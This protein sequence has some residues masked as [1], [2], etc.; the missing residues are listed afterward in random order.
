MQPFLHLTI[1]VPLIVLMSTIRSEA[2][3]SAADLKRHIIEQSIASYP[4]PCPCP[5]NIMRNGRR[6]GG[7]SAYVKPGGHAPICFPEDITPEMLKKFRDSRR[8]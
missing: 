2:Q 4:G 5:Y 1:A 6:C 8:E 3:T 7:F